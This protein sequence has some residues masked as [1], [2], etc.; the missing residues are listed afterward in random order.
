MFFNNLPTKLLVLH[1]NFKKAKAN[2]MISD[3]CKFLGVCP[4]GRHQSPLLP[5]PLL[6]QLRWK[7]QDSTSVQHRETYSNNWFQVTMS[8]IPNLKGDHVSSYFI[9]SYFGKENKGLVGQPAVECV[10]L[11]EDHSAAPSTHARWLTMAI[12]S[13]SRDPKPE[14]GGQWFQCRDSMTLSQREAWSTASFVFPGSVQTMWQ[15]SYS[16]ILPYILQNHVLEPD[17][18][19]AGTSSHPHSYVALPQDQSIPL[20]GLCSLPVAVSPCRLWTTRVQ[21]SLRLVLEGEF[22]ICFPFPICQGFVHSDVHVLS[23]FTY[24]L[25]LQLQKNIIPSKNRWYVWKQSQSYP[26]VVMIM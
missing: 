4:D 20:R 6:L 11:S 26:F 16:L 5:L 1:Q 21:C 15:Y 23:T 18:K 17:G 14:T 8:T 12:K 13:S 10:M 24:V 25:D 19:L 7:T 3:F 2:S 22:P 9:L